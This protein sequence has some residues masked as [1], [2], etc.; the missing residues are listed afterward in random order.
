MNTK[1]RYKF[2][3]RGFTTLVITIS[4]LILVISGVILYFTPSGR[5]V[6]M[7][8]WAFIGLD[9]FQWAMVHISISI[10]FLLTAVVHLYFNW[11]IFLRHFRT[12][13][14]EGFT[15]GSELI[16]SL[17]VGGI[18]VTGT[19]CQVPP[20][21]SVKKLHSDIRQYWEWNTGLNQPKPIGELDLH[22]IDRRVGVRHEEIEG[23]P[24]KDRRK[25]NDENAK[26]EQIGEHGSVPPETV[27]ESVCNQLGKTAQTHALRG[28]GSGLRWGQMTL[29]QL[30]AQQGLEL[31][32]AITS[33]KAHGVQASGASTLGEISRALGVKPSGLVE[34]IK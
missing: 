4:F 31:D 3:W 20:F 26:V 6:R 10:L 28:G 2:N 17:A 12:K 22:R 5:V 1:A 13:I 14:E 24:R 27:T 19:L 33:L 9:K 18:V 21:D 16:A 29:S 8:G 34:I 23:A 30:C 15:L 7:T 32:Q 25:T 11:R